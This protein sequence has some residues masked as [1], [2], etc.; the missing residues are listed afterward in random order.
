MFIETKS[1]RIF[2]YQEAIDIRCGFEKLLHFVRDRMKNNLNQG[3]LYLFL[4]K[5]RKRVKAL[6]FDGT[7]LVMIA[8]HIEQRRFMARNELCD[9]CE[10][11]QV[12]LKQIFNGGV[13]VRPRLDRSFVSDEINTSLPKRIIQ[14]QIHEADRSTSPHFK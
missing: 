3:H 4:G 11:T 2:I 9:L 7:G 14:Q 6:I 8:N 5:N 10:I 13:T 12:E 1:L